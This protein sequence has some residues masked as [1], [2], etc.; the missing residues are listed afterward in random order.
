[1]TPLPA[2]DGR[3]SGDKDDADLHTETNHTP[4]PTSESDQESIGNESET[5]YRR[6]VYGT[7]DDNG[8]NGNGG[9]IDE[10]ETYRKDSTATK[11]VRSRPRL[12]KRLSQ[13]LSK[14]MSRRRTSIIDSLPDT[15]AGWTVLVTALSSLGL[16]FE[17]NLQKSLTMP[18]TVY[19][20]VHTTNNGNGNNNYTNTLL[21][22]KVHAHLTATP[23]SILRRTIQPSL[24]VGTRSVLASTAA[25]LANGP[26]PRAKRFRVREVVTMPLDGARIALDWEFPMSTIS[27]DDDNVLQQQEGKTTAA[28][29]HPKSHVVLI[30]HGINNDASFGYIRSAMRACTDRGWAAV[31]VNFRGCGGVP[32]A[33]PRGYTGAY[34]G[35]MRGV[36]QILSG[37]LEKTPQ[38]RIFLVGN[39]LGANLV[40]K[41]LGEEGL[42]GTLPRCVAGGISLGNPL[43]LHSGHIQFPWGHI[44]SL[45][46]RKTILENI[47]IM[48][49]MTSSFFQKRIRMALMASTI[50]KF[51][52]ALAPIF[53]RNNPI[54]PF[55]PQIGYEDAE[56]YWKDA[57]SYR[58]VA[59][60]SVPFLQLSSEDDFLVST[61]SSQKLHYS[62]SNP[63]TLVVNTRCG[64]HLGWR[65]CPPDHKFG[66]GTS[67]A[68]R[69]TVD[70]IEA[71]LKASV[72]VDNESITEANAIKLKLMRTSA[73]EEAALLKSRL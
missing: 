11:L 39:S 26:R 40:A 24:F 32:L 56:Q 5:L 50:G 65:E 57:S 25:Y 6:R 21:L 37:R 43:H 19:R 69:A 10:D 35:D 15:P 61:S 1:M 36:V 52:E 71:V 53:I 54:P 18:P 22:D 48:R 73:E 8:D 66:L 51:D 16:G 34:T 70:F 45:G 12:I 67:W 14:E 31:G 2:T 20:Q 63:N 30:W 28:V 23:T 7:D 3:N 42:E 62:L 38:Y 44:L 58:Y 47:M 72:E 59:H 27:S 29:P 13:R 60:I 68:D 33:T 64:G 49:Q 41:Y 9:V 55:E 4:L 17:L 46:A